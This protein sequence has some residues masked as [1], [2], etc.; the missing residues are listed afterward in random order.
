MTS[1]NQIFGFENTE[2]YLEKFIHFEIK[3]N[4]GTVSDRVTE[5]YKEY[6]SMFD[7]TLFP[8]SDSIE[9]YFGA[10]FRDIDIRTQE[11][12]M[13]KIL[14]VHSLLYNDKKDYS[15]MC[16]EVLI[17][18]LF[19]A[20]G[21]DP[22]SIKTEYVKLEPWKKVFYVAGHEPA[23]SSFFENKFEKILFEKNHDLTHKQT[24]YI[25]QK[26]CRLYGAILLMWCWIHEKQ[27]DIIVQVPQGNYYDLLNNN[28]SELKKFIEVF[29]MIN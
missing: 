12:L 17:S 2:K 10:V 25:F 8:F 16:M 27:G 29:Q 28:I 5:K 7:K 4:I 20:Y 23:F 11:Q 19:S 26:K 21:A 9:E 1:I 24:Y 15:F 3:L 6:L 22:N 18:I 14:L 13:K